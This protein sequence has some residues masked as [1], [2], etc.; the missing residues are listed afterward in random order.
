M[1]AD[2]PAWAAIMTGGS[3]QARLS[4][5]QGGADGPHRLA[6]SPA[7]QKLL[8]ATPR[9][10]AGDDRRNRLHRARFDHFLLGIAESPRSARNPD[11]GF[12]HHHNAR[13][14]D[15]PVAR[16]AVS[17]QGGGRKRCFGA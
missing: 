16:R 12:R 9:T 14:P 4:G 2:L 7:A 15:D 5:R 6:R 11:R 10:D 13:H 1:I 3:K 17:R 8:R